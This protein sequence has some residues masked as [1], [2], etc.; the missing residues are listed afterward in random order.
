MRKLFRATAL[1]GALAAI[2][3]LSSLSGCGYCKPGVGGNVPGGKTA[4]YCTNQ[5]GEGP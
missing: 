3:A 1:C 5:A 2:V 4:A